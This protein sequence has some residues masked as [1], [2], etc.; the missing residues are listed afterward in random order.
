M[1]YQRPLGI[2]VVTFA[3]VVGLL[4]VLAVTTGG[5]VSNRAGA[6]RSGARHDLSVSPLHPVRTALTTTMG[7]ENYAFDYSTTFQPG[8]ESNQQ[9]SPP[10]DNDQRRR[11]RQSE[12]VCHAQHQLC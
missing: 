7:A 10:T 4:L 3:I 6:N 9:V 8:T 1:R 12:P 11:R 5:K 2:L